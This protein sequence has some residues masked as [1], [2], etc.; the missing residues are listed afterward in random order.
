MERDEEPPVFNLRVGRWR[1]WR[2]G[3]SRVI[4]RALPLPVLLGA[5]PSQDDSAGG[6]LVD[7]HRVANVGDL[8]EMLDVAVAQADA[9][10]RH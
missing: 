8:V 1:G 5:P 3:E 10:V 2:Q 9:A 4:L 6:A 7:D